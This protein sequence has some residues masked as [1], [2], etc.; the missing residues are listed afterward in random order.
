MR[1]QSSVPEA[2]MPSGAF[3]PI[4][5]TQAVGKFDHTCHDVTYN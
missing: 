5:D 1:T 2:R 4:R 3:A